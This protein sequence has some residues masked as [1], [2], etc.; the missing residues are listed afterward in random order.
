VPPGTRVTVTTDPRL[1]AMDEYGRVRGYPATTDVRDVALHLIEA[2]LV[3][4]WV[5]SGEPKPTRRATYT[6][7]QKTA[8]QSRTGSWATC[9][10]V[11]R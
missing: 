3:E 11:G 8:R 7:A 9:S 1:D 5:P 10:R 6:S 4:A 2:G